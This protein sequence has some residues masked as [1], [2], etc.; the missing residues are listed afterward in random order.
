MDCIVDSQVGE[1]S[2]QGCWEVAWSMEGDKLQLVRVSSE[3]TTEEPLANHLIVLSSSIG[4][5]VKSGTRGSNGAVINVQLQGTKVP[6]L[7]KA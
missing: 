2:T 5:G 3:A 6:G 1:R 4:G 7:C